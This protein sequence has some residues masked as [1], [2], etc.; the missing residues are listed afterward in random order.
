MSEACNKAI[1]RRVF[2]VFNGADIDC[3][4]QLIDPDMV[5]HEAFP[6]AR[7]TEQ[8]M[9]AEGDKVYLRWTMKA[10]HTGP[11][12]EREAT[13]RSVTHYGQECFE[14]RNGR[15]VQHWGQE[16]N[17]ELMQK[18]GLLKPTW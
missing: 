4:D 6:D 8:D 17:L 9:I 2:E 7:F 16:D 15:I 18:L 5:S 10:S 1:V 14:I 11:Y 12:M 3:L 13:G